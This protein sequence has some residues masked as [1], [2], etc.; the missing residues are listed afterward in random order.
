MVDFF[1][2]T[3]LWGGAIIETLCEDLT[4]ILIQRGGVSEI[5]STV[6]DT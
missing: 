2:V 5:L 6:D 1:E 4:F 3:F